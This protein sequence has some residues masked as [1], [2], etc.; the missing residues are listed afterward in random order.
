MPCRRMGAVR[1][2]STAKV[3][4]DGRAPPVLAAR[5]LCLSAYTGAVE[6]SE[7]GRPGCRRGEGRPHEDLGDRR[8]RACRDKKKSLSAHVCPGGRDA[9]RPRQPS[10]STP[11]SRVLVRR[12]RRPRAS[13][14]SA[15]F[16]PAEHQMPGSPYRPVRPR[17]ENPRRQRRGRTRPG[18]ASSRPRSAVPVSGFGPPAAPRW[19]RAGKRR[20]G[21]WPFATRRGAAVSPAMGPATQGHAHAGRASYE[22]V[23]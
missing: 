2:A 9:G 16:G 5:L 1:T 7:G 14:S 19:S 21:R 20:E 8:E 6:V 18:S 4:G 23:P 3:G 10:T 15:P 22:R 17:F 12:R 11:R 13:P